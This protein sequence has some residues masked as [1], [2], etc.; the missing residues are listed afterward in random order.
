MVRYS[1]GPSNHEDQEL[2]DACKKEGA[3]EGNCRASQDPFC[4]VEHLRKKFDRV[5]KNVQ[6]LQE[7]SKEK[8]SFEE[9]VIGLGIG[10]LESSILAYFSLGC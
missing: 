6:I 4:V 3:V 7:I 2:E 5:T 10:A 9:R 1:T 8:K